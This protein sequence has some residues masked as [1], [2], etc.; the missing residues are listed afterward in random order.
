MIDL[1]TI[2][3][4]NQFAEISDPQESKTLS[5]DT[6]TLILNKL[7]V[8]RLVYLNRKVWDYNFLFTLFIRVLLDAGNKPVGE[9]T[10]LAPFDF[11]VLVKR[12][13]SIGWC[14]QKPAIDIESQMG[15]IKV[16]ILRYLSHDS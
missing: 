10:L 13:L 2:I 12:N 14:K 16:I 3:M 11:N 4:K 1:G 6:I 15:A 9:S 7:H 5:M 8:T